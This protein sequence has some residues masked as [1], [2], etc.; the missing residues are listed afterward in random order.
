M[1]VKAEFM[2]RHSIEVITTYSTLNDHRR[3]GMDGGDMDTIIEKVV[4]D[5]GAITRGEENMGKT[6]RLRDSFLH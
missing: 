2:T 1:S 4:N 3:S 5:C 6:V